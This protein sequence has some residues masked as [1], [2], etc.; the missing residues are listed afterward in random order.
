MTNW[1]FIES[2]AVAGAIEAIVEVAGQNFIPPYSSDFQP[3]II[4][5]L[6]DEALLQFDLPGGSTLKPYADAAASSIGTAINWL[7][8][9]LAP[10]MSVYTWVV[11]FIQVIKGIIEVLCALMNPF[12]VKRAVKRLIKTYLPKLI[13]LFPP[14]AGA[15]I[16]LNIIK[17]A[18]AIALFIMT[19]VIPM[20]QL[21]KA[22][23]ETIAKVRSSN[24]QKVDAAKKKIDGLI[25]E[26]INQAG[27]LKALL[28]ILDVVNLIQSIPFPCKKDCCDS[29]V[30]P[31]LLNNPPQGS[32]LMTPVDFGVY[33]SSQP[34]AYELDTNNT[35]IGG[36]QQYNQSTAEQA[37]AAGS[38]MDSC[39][40]AGSTAGDCP[41]FT[42]NI[43][44]NK[45]QAISA[46]VLAIGDTTLTVG[47][48]DLVPFIG[49]VTYAVL[50][51][52]VMLVARGVISI[53]CHPEIVQARTDMD[54]AFPNL[55]V[56]PD[57]GAIDDIIA[58]SAG[59]DGYAAGLQANPYDPG[60]IQSIQ[61]GLLKLLQDFI[62]SLKLRAHNALLGMLNLANSTLET[63]KTVVR[64][65][66][67]DLAV[68]SVIP[69]DDAGNAIMANCTSD[70]ILN[71]ELYS[72]LGTLSNQR[73]DRPNGAWLA[74][75]TSVSTGIAQITAKIETKFIYD[76]VSGVQ[77]TRVIDVAFV[78]DSV[79]PARRKKA[80]VVEKEPK[81]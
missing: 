10:V 4:S 7:L 58:A 49:A 80:A 71:V 77:T 31:D 55:E 52:Y 11:A 12:A 54:A 2:E 18:L 44:N 30:C 3:S 78:S 36:L 42:V 43:I 56:T 53:G 35:D 45:G 24:P 66:G 70:S 61:D 22:N 29:D 26:F 62:N 50:P 8:A 14:L 32:A 65:G 16:I 38:S 37:S 34:F 40:P 81:P 76:L 63:D 79:L 75:L 72:T 39:C 67:V 74:D 64:A 57:T 23:A 27:V 9:G 15:V 17:L 51:N 20:L 6:N 5:N 46:P 21:I 13:A 19:V 60:N 1:H 69:R 41:N 33:T 25:I 48:A 68:V 47:S 59:F 73:F 28:P